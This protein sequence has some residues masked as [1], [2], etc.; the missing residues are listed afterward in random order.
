MNE[1]KLP[2]LLKQNPL[3]DVICEFRFKSDF[4]VA[5]VLLGNVHT[6]FRDKN[7]NIIRLFDAQIPPEVLKQIPELGFSPK[8]RIEL[9]EF[10]VQIG[11]NLFSI[12]AMNNYTDWN[13]FKSYIKSVFDFIDGLGL[14]KNFERLSMKYVNLLESERIEEISS[15]TTLKIFLS[16]NDYTNSNFNL[17]VEKRKDDGIIDVISIANTIRAEISKILEDGSS[18]KITKSGIMLDVD[19][20][21]NLVVGELSKD[22]L[23]AALDKIH[24]HCKEIFFSSITDAA[25]QKMD[26]VYE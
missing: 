22:T 9:D 26:A 7:P 25:L 19:C 1:K 12:A 16:D 3:I 6:H 11:D 14:V 4:Q 15:L 13:L 17:R 18:A 5:E 8:F 24:M 20:I 23:E 2:N 21:K 10:S